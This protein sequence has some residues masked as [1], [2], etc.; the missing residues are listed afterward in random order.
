M[1][2]MARGEL[3]REQAEIAGQ[4]KLVIDTGMIKRKK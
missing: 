4:S 3:E 2:R 1:N